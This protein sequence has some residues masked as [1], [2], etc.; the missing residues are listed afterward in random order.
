LTNQQNLVNVGQ[1]WTNIQGAGYSDTAGTEAQPGGMMSAANMS[2]NVQTLNQIGGALQQLNSDGTVNTAATQQLIN[3]IQAQLGGNFTQSTVTSD[4]NTSF[5]KA[6][7]NGFDPTMVVEAVM[8]VMLSIMTAGAAAAAMGT[9]VAAMTVPEAMAAAA[10]SG[11]VGSTAGQ[12]ISGNGFSFAQ[13]F[14]AGA[15]G[16]LT[17]GLTDGIT[18]NSTTGSLGVTPWDQGLNSLAQN[19]STLGQLAGVASVGSALAGTV[20]QAGAAAGSLSEEILAAGADA[21]ITA[22]VQTAIEGGLP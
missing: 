1:I 14:E 3:S 22:G 19:T 10:A 21:T 7:G 16:A 5:T 2:L 4:L 8:V 13:V 17:A 6:G 18:Y 12:L 11:M 15:V 20:P 9:T